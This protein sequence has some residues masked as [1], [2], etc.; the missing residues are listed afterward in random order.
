MRRRGQPPVALGLFFDRE[1]RTLSYRVRRAWLVL[2]GA[3]C[4][5]ALR[6]M[7]G[8]WKRPG[9][10]ASTRFH[11]SAV[12]PPVLVQNGDVQVRLTGEAG[13][14]YEIKCRAI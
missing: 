2:L 7:D 12:R 14:R 4:P 11:Q 13:R 10:A 1:E 8:R 6:L 5:A 9:Q 3:S